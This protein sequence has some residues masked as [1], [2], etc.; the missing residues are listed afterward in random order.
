MPR[1]RGRGLLR[2]LGRLLAYGYLAAVLTF[3]GFIVYGLV[4]PYLGRLLSHP[5]SKPPEPVTVRGGGV[6]IVD[7][8]HHTDP[9]FTE[10]A[11][12]LLKSMGYRVRI[13]KDDE[14][15]VSFYKRLPTLG[16][17]LY[18]LRVHAGVLNTSM[19]THLF[20]SEEYDKS[21]HWIEQL[22]DQVAKGM[23][24]PLGGEKPVFTVG[25][26]FVEMS[27]Q[28]NFRGATIILSS[29]LGLYNHRLAKAFIE[30]GAGAFISWDE[31]VTL[32]HTDR[33]ALRLL[34]LLLANRMTIS[35]AVSRVMEEV[36]VD[37]EYGAILRFYPR[38]A[39]DL[40]V[41]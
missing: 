38:K 26:F 32:P 20:T 17:G 3:A 2:R 22:T 14:V 6:V 21:S 39:G 40:R 23:V 41:E 4:S 24:N 25:P 31:K 1:R 29:C 12:R 9:S 7:Q 16:A 27:M 11:S 34:E 28:G 35:E 15:T 19:E 30:K 5:E 10:E 33:A 8:F 37:P 18:V 36:G 13:F